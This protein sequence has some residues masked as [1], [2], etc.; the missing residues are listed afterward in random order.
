MT[1]GNLIINDGGDVYIKAL[2]EITDPHFIW[3][4]LDNVHDA[5]TTLAD[6]AAAVSRAQRAALAASQP[7]QG[8]AATWC[9]PMDCGKHTPR[10]WLIRFE[11]QSVGDLTFD[12]EAEARRMWEKYNHDW[13]CYLMASLP[14]LAASQ[15]AQPPTVQ[16]AARRI[17]SDDITISHMAQA[18]H[19]GPLGADDHWFSAARPQ[20]AWC[21]DAVRVVLR[22]IAEGRA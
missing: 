5:E 9:Q 20:G 16:D 8:E 7:A 3:E 4:A 6:Y 18:L 19:D 13:N 12:N 15:P 10:V 14:L 22:A 11:D 1:T 21:V 17:L 2:E